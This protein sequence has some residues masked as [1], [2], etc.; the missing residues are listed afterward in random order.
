M[1]DHDALL[2]TVLAYRRSKPLLVA[3]DYDLFTWV[4]RG[5]NTAPAL[6][7]RLKLDARA[8]AILLD[9]VA[10]TGFLAKHRNRYRNTP[11]G[12]DLLVQ[13]SPNYRGSNLKYQEATWQAWSD[14]KGVVKTGRPKDGLLQ[15]IHK[16]AF[17][18]DYIKAMGD[19]A[20]EP[21]RDLA[22]KLGLAGTAKS[23]DV[24][25]GAGSYS[26]ALVAR[27]P[28]LEATL[29]DLPRPLGVARRL[30]S[31]HPFAGRFRF[32]AGDFLKDSFGTREFDLVLISNVTH[33]ESAANNR[34]LV[35]KAFKALRPGGRLVVHDY[36]SDRGLTSPRF[37]AMLAVHLLVFTGRGNVYTLGQY[38]GWLRAAGFRGLRHRR[39]AAG[40]SYPSLAVIGTKP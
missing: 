26:A 17:A 11:L 19:V 31:E 24:G 10:A 18:E 34:L 40:G 27:N 14:L 16:G 29:F 28:A 22:A 1:S 2:D 3:L 5:W 20:R 6:A 30:L 32:K 36:V 39:V 12:K 35:Q 37:A 13:D 9:A 25:S 21:A 23:L 4:E 38:S 33:C 8:V 7:R 15:W